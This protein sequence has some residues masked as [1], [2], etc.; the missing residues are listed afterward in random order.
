MMITREI[1]ESHIA[2]SGAL[3]NETGRITASTIAA[4]KGMNVKQ[5]GTDKAEY[6]TVKAGAD[7]HIRWIA[8]KYDSQI[9]DKQKELDITVAKKMEY[10]EA[11]NAFHVDIANQTFA[12]EKITKKMDF[13]EN[14]MGEVKEKEERERITKE[15]KELEISVQQADE[16]IKAIF[17]EQDQA[18][19]Q[20]SEC[21]QKIADITT[22][23]KTIEDEKQKIVG[24]LEREEAVAELKVTK[25]LYTGT[26]VTGSQASMIL[27]QDMGASKFNE[28]DSENPDN[29]KQLIHQTINV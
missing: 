5:I 8:Q 22:E 16:R 21:E 4:R 1:M 11:F 3:N 26:R 7:D 12:Q 13:L 20:S 25:K 10:D 6:S 24:R 27:K 18:Q 9:E 17:Q 14:Q 29:P 15:L 2:I 28:I 19:Q 23:I